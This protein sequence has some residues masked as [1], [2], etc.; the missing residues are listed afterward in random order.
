MIKFIKVIA[1]GAAFV[2][3]GAIG[4][5]QFMPEELNIA[6]RMAGAVSLIVVLAA[7]ITFPG[8]RAIFSSTKWK[9]LI[10]APMVASFFGYWITKFLTNS[11][12]AAHCVSGVF[13]QG[14]GIN[15]GLHMT[16]R[17]SR[18]FQIG[19][20]MYSAYGVIKDTVFWEEFLASQAEAKA[21]RDAKLKGMFA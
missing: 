5:D 1:V 18:L 9:A 12:R 6:I 15:Q 17:F 8:F 7:L 20:S 21:Y 14:I 11:K 10:F 3:A 13:S 19:F 2:A 16:G 4:V